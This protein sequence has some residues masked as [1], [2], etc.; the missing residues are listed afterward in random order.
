MSYEHT[1]KDS[2]INV[3][4][5]LHNL[6]LPLLSAMGH[7]HVGKSTILY[8][9][10]AKFVRFCNVSAGIHRHSFLTFYKENQPHLRSAFTTQLAFG[11]P[12]HLHC[13]AHCLFGAQPLSPCHPCAEQRNILHRQGS[14][15]SKPAALQNPSSTLAVLLTITAPSPQ[16]ATAVPGDS[17]PSYRICTASQPPKTPKVL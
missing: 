14:R 3:V 1:C 2:S 7:A 12:I 15:Q 13:I 4:E 10:C 17:S 9:L 16:H 6:E 11:F 5:Q 8:T